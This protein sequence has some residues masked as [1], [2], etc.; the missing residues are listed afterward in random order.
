MSHL[1]K[2]IHQSISSVVLVCAKA[3]LYLTKEAPQI[4]KYIANIMHYIIGGAK[5]HASNA[6]VAAAAAAAPEVAPASARIRPVT[7]ADG[8]VLDGSPRPARPDRFGGLSCPR[9]TMGN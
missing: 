7:G 4:N 3:V 6:F 2:C 5:I 8:S 9:R 1:I